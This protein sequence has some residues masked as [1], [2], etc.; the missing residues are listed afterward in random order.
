MIKSDFQKYL[1]A[2]TVAK[3]SS[4]ELRARFVVEGFI[5]GLH[6]S[7]Y[8]GF[9]VEFAEHRQYMPG[10]EIKK[11]DWKVF[12]RTDRFYVKQFEEETNLRAY[13]IIDASK[14]M[15]FKLSGKVSKLEYATYLASAL[16]LMMIRQ[17]DAVG[18]TIYDEN[19]RTFLPPKASSIYLKEIFKELSNVK[20]RNKTSTAN[21][22]HKIAE[23]VKKRSLIIIFSDLFDE[24]KNILNTLKHFRHKKNEVIVFHILDP[25]EKDFSFSNDSIFLDMETNEKISTQPNHIKKTYQKAMKEFIAHYQKE[26]RNQLI[27]YCLVDTSTSFDVPLLEYLHKRK[28][29]F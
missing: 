2:E 26:C 18:L 8:H 20:G 24:P 16:S 29:L 10:D 23:Q 21:S 17:K 4:M 13:L 12:G 1:D 14:S 25:A 15:S 22:L 11:I 6:K 7:P 28:K 27:D 19:V 9:S 3:I 5:T